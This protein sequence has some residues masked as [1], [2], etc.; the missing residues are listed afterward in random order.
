MTLKDVINSTKSCE[1]RNDEI[2]V[3]SDGTISWY[4]YGTLIARYEHEEIEFF[5]LGFSTSTSKRHA[6]IALRYQVYNE[7]KAARRC[8]LNKIRFIVG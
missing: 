3:A 4:Y 1:Y 5:K 7:Y 8:Q 2:V 6:L